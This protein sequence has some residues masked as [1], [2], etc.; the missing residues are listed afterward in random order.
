[1]IVKNIALHSARVALAATF[2]GCFKPVPSPPTLGYG[3]PYRG[4]GQTIFVK[5]SRTDWDITEGT[6]RI[7]AEQALEASGDETYERRRQQMKEYNAQLER[8]GKRNRRRGYLITG[9]G[10]ATM[11]VGLITSYGLAPNMTS[12]SRTAATA[13]APEMLETGNKGG[14]Y[15]A[16]LF[17]GTALMYGGAGAAVYAQIFAR[18]DPPYVPWKIPPTL[19]RPAYIRRAAEDYN[20]KLEKAAPA[21]TNDVRPPGELRPPP[22]RPRPAIPRPRGGRR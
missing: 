19:N 8:E 21:P 17:L 2:A 5:D 20:A 18:K 10:I 15:L 22:F 12:E 13:T 1:M 7:S 6:Q 14:A 16:V 9:G 3:E 11:I 4:T